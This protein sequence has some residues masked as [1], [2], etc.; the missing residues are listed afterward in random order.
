MPLPTIVLSAIVAC[1]RD[2][3]TIGP[4]AE[5]LTQ[6]FLRLGVTYEIIF[7]NDASP[8]G[9]R[10][11]LDRLALSD[12]RVKVIAHSRNFGSQSAFYSGLRVARGE[13][14]IFLD[15]DLQDPPEVIPAFFQKWGDGFDVVYGIRD[16]REM[17]WVAEIF[18]RAYY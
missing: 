13:A 17:A 5:R 18:Y 2:E 10:A 15:G 1:Y 11:V 16:R 14:C 3:K 8:D 12:S 9:S 6:V 7:V 4:M